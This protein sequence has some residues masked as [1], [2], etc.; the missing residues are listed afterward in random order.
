[1]KKKKSDFKAIGD[2]INDY[3]SWNYSLGN[4]ILCIAKEMNI[5][6][7]ISDKIDVSGNE[8]FVGDKLHISL[9]RCRPEK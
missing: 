5:K 2:V 3:M 7:E 6:L 8:I 9:D 1:M 4:T